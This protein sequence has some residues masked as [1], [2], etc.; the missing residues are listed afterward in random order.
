MRR[1][2]CS[3]RHG[4]SA[5]A[6]LRR[7]TYDPPRPQAPGTIG[8]TG[9]RMYLLLPVHTGF[10]GRRGAPRLHVSH[11]PKPDRA[12]HA[13]QSRRASVVPAPPAAAAT[14]A[15]CLGR[16]ASRQ[17]ATLGPCWPASVA[18]H[19]ARAPLLPARLHGCMA[20][21]PRRARRASSRLA[22]TG[23]VSASPQAHAFVGAAA[24]LQPQCCQHRET[25]RSA[26]LRGV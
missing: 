7:S 13:R 9:A 10:A 3:M 23:Q 8:R 16:V 2:A 11:G 25:A 24:S 26:C 15:A 20:A 21:L 12:P 14:P 4:G 5:C 1:A 6:P 17:T 22:T 18:A 19:A